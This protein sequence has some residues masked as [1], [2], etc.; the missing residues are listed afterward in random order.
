MTIVLRIY[1]TS[2]TPPAMGFRWDSSKT[3]SGGH[4]AG[5]LV[6]MVI[7]IR[8]ELLRQ[9]RAA[10]GSTSSQL[11]PGGEVDLQGNF[12]VERRRH[13]AAH[14]L[15][16]S[17]ISSAGASKTSSS[18]IWRSIRAWKSLIAELPVEQ[19][20]G[21]LDQIGGRA[22]DDGVDRRPLGQVSRPAGRR[23][24]AVDRPPAAQDRLDAPG[25][26]RATRGSG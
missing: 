16:Q 18:W 8:P 12:Q 13:L 17:G 3:E 21:P 2:R 5:R 22:L 11:R 4:L 23:F 26:L 9:S 6:S 7:R 19:D 14:Q 10:I 25:R 1:T 15:G 24:D 20:H